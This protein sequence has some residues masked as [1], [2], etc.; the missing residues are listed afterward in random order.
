M[1]IDELQRL[2]DEVAEGS[3]AKFALMI[4]KSPSQVN[5][6]LSGLRP[7]GPKIEM[8]IH[9][10][11]GRQTSWAYGINAPKNARVKELA[12]LLDS[13]Q[14][15]QFE[16]VDVLHRLLA[17]LVAPPS[18]A[19]IPLAAHFKPTSYDGDTAVVLKIMQKLKPDQRSKAR[20]MLQVAFD[21]G[22]PPDEAQRQNL[23]VPE[24]ENAAA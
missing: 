2:I 24:L 6:W 9:R 23:P 16:I 10:A 21:E 17:S 11:L 3:Q 12:R 1:T 19:V 8:D 14:G 5:Q 7:I 15:S 22:F 4:H 20:A 13:L 18:Q